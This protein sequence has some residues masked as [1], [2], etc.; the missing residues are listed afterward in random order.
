[1]SAQWFNYAYHYGIGGILF[2]LGMTALIKG[3]ALRWE[4]P[5][6]RLLIKGLIG[7]LVTFAPVHAVWILAAGLS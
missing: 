3:G 5:S 1:M 2:L 7:G 6:D 4:R